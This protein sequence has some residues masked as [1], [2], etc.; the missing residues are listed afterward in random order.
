MYIKGKSLQVLFPVGGLGSRFKDKG[1]TQ[2][3]PLINVK[4]RPM[5]LWAIESSDNL[6]KPNRIILSV[7][8]QNQSKLIKDSL[9]R[10]GINFDLFEF[11]ECTDGAIQTCLKARAL[12]DVDS[13]LL[14]VDCDIAFESPTLSRY[15]MNDEI[16][17]DAFLTVFDSNEP[18]FSYAQIEGDRVICT[19]EKKAISNNAIIGAYFFSTGKTFLEYADRTI[20]QGLGDNKEFYMS[21]IFNHMI[22]DGK[23]VNWG[24]GSFLSFGT[25][26]ELREFDSNS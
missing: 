16:N 14:V 7:R 15:L 18:R 25:P 8:D 26:E 12:I 13:P 11:E 22:A 21:L 23:R 10:S 3:K 24:K 19:V 2:F 1:Y 4:N 9:E 5:I 17:F 6:Y 20:K